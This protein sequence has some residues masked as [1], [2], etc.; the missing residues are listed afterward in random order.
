MGYNPFVFFVASLIAGFA[1]LGMVYPYGPFPSRRT[2]LVAAGIGCLAALLFSPLFRPTKVVVRMPAS[3]RV[4]EPL[5]EIA[6]EPVWVTADRLNKRTCPSV[7]CGMTG[8]VYRGERA[9]VLERRNGWARVSAYTD[10]RCSGGVTP[11]VEEGRPDC[12][13]ENGIA[14]GTYAE[15]VAGNYLSAEQP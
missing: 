15:W 2:A 14:D 3:V 8:G 13:A 1:V 9:V 12:N 6:G 10:A 5:P 7:D 11:L 4:A